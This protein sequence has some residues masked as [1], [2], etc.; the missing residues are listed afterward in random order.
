M[1][2][3]RSS[4]IA[5]AIEIALGVVAPAPGALA[6]AVAQQAAKEPGLAARIERLQEDLDQRR[7][8][9]HISGLSLAVVL[10]GEVVFA[11]GCGLRDRAANLPADEHTIYG[12][13]STSK[14]FTS[15]LC[16]MLVDEEKLDWNARPAT[17]LPWFAFRDPGTN[18]KATL[19]DLL[20]HRTGL[21]RTDVAW[22]GTDAT[23]EQLMRLIATTDKQADYGV[24]WQYNNCMLLVAGEAA[25]KVAGKPSWDEL[26]AERIFAP[27]GMKNATSSGDAAFAHPRLSSRY[28][29][30]AAKGDWK[31]VEWLD[32]DNMAPA[33]GIYS[34]VTDMAKWVQ[35]LLRR[36]VQ[37]GRALVS[38]KQLDAMWQDTRDDPFPRYGMGW[39]LHAADGKDPQA[40]R[41]PAGVRHVVIEHG[42]NVPGYAA[43]VALVPD[44]DCGVVM[45]ANTSAT[46]FQAGVLPFVLDT[47]FGPLRERKAWIDGAPLLK[48]QWGKWLGAY[49]GG[50][51]GRA[52][53]V[54]IEQGDR[55]TLVIPPG[56]GQQAQTLY[57]LGWPDADGRS[58]IREEPDAW[59]TIDRDDTGDATSLTLNHG[60]VVR[61]MRRVFARTTTQST[62]LTLDEFFA[63]REAVIHGSKAAEWSTLRL[64]GSVR[65][66]QAGVVGRYTLAARGAESMRIDVDA[67]PFGFATT[68]IDGGR[69]TFRAHYG[70]EPEL[71]AARVAAMPLLNPIGEA[72]SWLDWTD[73]IELRGIVFTSS[74]GMP[75]VIPPAVPGLAPIPDPCYSILVTPPDAPPIN[76]YV[77]VATLKTVAI[78]GADA[79]F[80]GLASR[81]PVAVLADWRDVGGVLLPF[82]RDMSLP[83]IGTV[84]IQIEQAEVD[85][86]LDAALFRL[87][88]PAAEQTPAKSSKPPAPKPGS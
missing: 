80:P 73:A 79:A 87:P 42:G 2:Q 27:L 68:I 59:I 60:D 53:T 3:A 19:R 46:Q 69:G 43:E 11:G 36:G 76:Y 1:N 71:D 14:A 37:D 81:P 56:L 78:E 5:I 65:F 15:M 52:N 64:S 33:G 32:M 88:S 29:W 28:D 23:R 21:T 85:I 48:E 47:L 55:L 24:A 58:W 20:S 13:G 34:D 18:E 35:F 26:L 72:G 6:Q 25:A 7:Q 4:V 45:L 38:G 77:S 67:K 39:F 12:I 9:L 63:K 10:K 51:E 17:W 50:M 66:L 82:H 54:L 16:A 83:D 31:P 70:S 22:V 40:W 8:L 74:I 44:L 86:E 30:D 62:P 57:T 49:T 61:K 75:L 41:D 84:V